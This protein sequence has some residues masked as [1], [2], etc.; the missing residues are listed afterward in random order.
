MIDGW[1]FGTV[2]NKLAEIYFKKKGEKIIFQ[3]HCYV[4]KSDYRTKKEQQFIEKD[5][6]KVRLV[7]R[8]SKY[9]EKIL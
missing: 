4:K 6:E 1:C 3:G 2:N 9:K 8:E 5:T 7:Y